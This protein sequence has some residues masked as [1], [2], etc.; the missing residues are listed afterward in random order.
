MNLAKRIL[1]AAIH[2]V[3]FIVLAAGLSAAS[4][5]AN[6]IGSYITL[7]AGLMGLLIACQFA[8]NK[9]PAIQRVLL[10]PLKNAVFTVL[11]LAAIWMFTRYT[12]PSE[13]HIFKNA[14]YHT[15][16]HLGF[17]YSDSLWLTNE[18]APRTAL[19][20]EHGGSLLLRNIDSNNVFA[21][22][23]N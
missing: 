18:A 10:P 20:D 14:D 11:A 15:L 12:H 21:E 9:I 6:T 13:E 1:P 2:T 22:L 4:W 5:L 16:E 3:L 7:A 17:E 19:W 8:S 23:S